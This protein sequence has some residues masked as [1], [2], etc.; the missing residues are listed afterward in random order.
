MHNTWS[1]TLSYY[2]IE[3]NRHN[4][5][6]YYYYFRYPAPIPDPMLGQTWRPSTTSELSYLIISKEM[7]M[8]HD[9]RNESVIFWEKM[10]KTMSW[11]SN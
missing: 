11:K 1:Y 5:Y 8:H 4:Y 7:N 6:Y 9:L 10:Y 3:Q 2:Y